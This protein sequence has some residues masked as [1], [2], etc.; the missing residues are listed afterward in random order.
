MDGRMGSKWILRRLGWDGGM[1]WIQVAQVR[2]Q[3]QALVNTV[4]NL[5][6]LAPRS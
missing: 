2:D 4:M 5:H 6:V 3:S 1:K